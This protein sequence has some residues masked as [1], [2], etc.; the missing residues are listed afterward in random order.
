[1]TEKERLQSL[2]AM[3]NFLCENDEED[4]EKDSQL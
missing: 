2:E 1:M 3:D 4:D